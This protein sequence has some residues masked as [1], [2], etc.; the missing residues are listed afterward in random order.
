MHERYFS[1]YPP[2]FTP[3][4]RRQ[5]VEGPA[6]HGE[7]SLAQVIDSAA[8]DGP[9]DRERAGGLSWSSQNR[10]LDRVSALFGLDDAA[11]REAVSVL[12]G[13]PM[14]GLETAARARGVRARGRALRGLLSEISVDVLLGLGA[15]AG[16]WGPPNRWDQTRDRLIPLDC[17]TPIW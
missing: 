13:L 11:R 16:L 1:V 6:Q 7:P 2:G 15:L 10:L 14:L 17:A 4:A 5:L 9:G 12:V 8:D 3:Y